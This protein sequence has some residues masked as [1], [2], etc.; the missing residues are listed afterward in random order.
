MKKRY[1]FRINRI[2]DQR[3]C[4]SKSLRLS[5]YHD[6]VEKH[7]HKQSSWTSDMLYKII[8]SHFFFKYVSSFLLR[9]HIIW[10]QFGHFI[11]HINANEDIWL[12]KSKIQK[13]NENLFQRQN[14]SFKSNFFSKF[15]FYFFR[16]FFDFFLIFFWS[17]II[18]EIV[19]FSVETS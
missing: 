18:E 9:F 17:I 10:N 6:F 16:F 15:F 19:K 8:F 5:N 11:K 14:T 3:V 7:V 1:F 12:I 2:S 4:E 13:W